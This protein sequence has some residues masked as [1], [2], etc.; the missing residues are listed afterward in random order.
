MARGYPFIPN[1]IYVFGAG[2]GWWLAIVL[3]ATLREKITYSDIPKNLQGMAI[4]FIIT[5]LMAL[6]FMGFAGI[7]LDETEKKEEPIFLSF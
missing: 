3:I 6:A 7:T 4:T 2:L 1:L 5:G